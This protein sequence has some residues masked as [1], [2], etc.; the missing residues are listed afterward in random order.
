MIMVKNM[1]QMTKKELIKATK[2]RYLKAIKKDKTL[3]LNEFCLSTG[4]DRKYAITILAAGYDNNRV[5]SVGRKPRKKKYQSNVLAVVE[6]IWELLDY[7]CGVRLASVLKE[8]YQVLIRCHELR[9]DEKV[10]G[11]IATISPSTIDRRLKRQREAKHLKRYRGMTHPGALLK[12]QIPIRLTDWSEAKIGEMEIDTVAHNGGDPSGEFAFSLDTVDIASGWSEQSCQ[13]SKGETTTLESLKNIEQSLPFKVIGIDSDSGGE[14]INWHLLKYCQTTKKYFTRSRPD[15]KNDN[16]FIEE[17][18]GARVRR[19]LGFGRYDTLDQ[20]RL[21]NDLYR[22]ELRLY[23]NFFL[24]VMKIKSKE[25]I[26]NSICRKRYDQAQTPY[27]R[28]LVS[29]QISQARKD[30]LTKLYLSLN[31]VQLKRI[32]DEKVRRIR[33]TAK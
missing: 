13:L 24:P 23:T 1:T 12:N 15:R 32:I 9:F 27:R 2:P 4:Y 31:P 6:K 11:Q 22:N 20:V 30:E 25:K 7:P 29:P 16:A 5:V 3:I 18:N 10:E 19:W 21:I 14:F 28:L 8:N 26:N 17:K 33:A